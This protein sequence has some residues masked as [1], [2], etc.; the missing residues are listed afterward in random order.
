VGRGRWPEEDDSRRLW[1]AAS[2]KDRAENLMIVDLLR[3]DLGRIAE[4]GSVEVEGLFGIERFETLWQMTSTVRA[5]PRDGT[6]LM[7]VLRALFPSGSITGAPKART[8]EIIREL[9]ATPRGLYCGAIGLLAPPGSGQPR[10]QFNVAIRTVVVDAVAGTAVYGTGGGITWDSVPENEYDEALV[11]TAVLT[12]RQAEFS[13]LETMRWTPDEGVVRRQRHLDRLRA[14]ADYFGF[15]YPKAAIESG[16][17]NLESTGDLRVRLLL[18]RTGQAIVEHEPLRQPGTPVRLVIDGF[19]VDSD[20][21][22][23]FHKT[24]HRD[25][26]DQAASRHPEADDVVLVNEKGMATETTRANLAAR[27]GD[28]WVTPPLEDGCLPGTYRAELIEDGA[29]REQ[30]ILAVSLK[31][32]H[33]LAVVSSLRGWRPAVLNTPVG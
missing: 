6:G 27:F 5:V 30:S 4:Y 14:S 9:E 29:L 19:Q 25:V 11:K 17:T 32:A 23:L 16:L 33:E 8:M 24:T 10:A 22:L 31:E 15:A 12:H 18:D 2:E 7:A 1:L 28:S 13:L 20:N 21:V 3:N 26:Y